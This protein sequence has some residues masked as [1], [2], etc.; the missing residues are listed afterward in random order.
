MDL[1]IKLGLLL[2]LSIAVNASDI[3]VYIPKIASDLITNV[4]D[5]A[6]VLVQPNCIFNEYTTTNVWLVIALNKS[7]STLN[8]SDLGTPVPYA[9]YIN[10]LYQYYHTLLVSAGQYPCSTSNTA[11]KNVIQVGC[12]SCTT[13]PF[14]NGKLSNKETYRVKFVL[15]NSSGIFDE[16]QWS[17]EISLAQDIPFQGNVWPSGRSGGMIVVTSILSVLLAILLICLITALVF[18]SRDICFK[19]TIL[20]EK[21]KASKMN[22]M[23]R[24]TYRSRYDHIY[25]VS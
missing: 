7:F 5:N 8:D 13:N 9:S 21:S 1:H 14:C 2:V 19:R 17:S 18:G 16:T 20:N 6:F 3:S 11:S 22:F 4:T 15:L 24:S 23:S 25:L 12:E 10:G